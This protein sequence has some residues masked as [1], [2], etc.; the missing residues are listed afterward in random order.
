MDHVDIVI[1]GAGVVGLAIAAKLVE[2]YPGYQVIVLERNEKFGQ[3][4]S[5]RNSEVIHSGIYYPEGSLK[6]ELCVTGN[7]LL[8]DFCEENNVPYQKPGKM[9]IAIEKNDMASLQDLAAKAEIN[10]VKNVEL[11]T[12]EMAKMMEPEIISKGALLVPSTGIIDSHTL[13]KRLEDI[14]MQGGAMLAYCHEIKDIEPYNDDYKVEFCNPDGS[15]DSISCTWLI[16]SAGLYSDRIAEMVGIDIDREGY[17]IHPCKGEYFS[18]TYSKGK[19]VEKLIYPPPLKDLQGLGIHLTKSLDGRLRLGPNAFYV[20]EIDYSVNLDHCD[21]F[22]NS[23]KS[24]LPFLELADLEPEMAGIRPKLQGPDDSFK[25][26]I[27]RHES[28]RSLNG[29]IN[30][31]GIESPGL[32]CCLSIAD[33]VADMFKIDQ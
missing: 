25:D 28:A 23:V 1:V 11:L 14:A 4:T 33:K 12:P 16:N 20:D 21:D 22:F 6:A 7:E 17:R 8:Y 29:I 24:F 3:E 10:N 2:K 32:T 27:I 19:L 13:M 31:V 9:I 15:C 18:I 5:S 26:F 30:L